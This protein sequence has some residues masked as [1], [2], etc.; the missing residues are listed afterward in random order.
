[1]PA[2]TRKPV[3]IPSWAGAVVLIPNGI[4]GFPPYFPKRQFTPRQFV[5]AARR[6]QLAR[7][8]GEWDVLFYAVED[9]KRAG[10]L[11]PYGNHYT[12]LRGRHGGRVKRLAQSS[13]MDEPPRRFTTG[14]NA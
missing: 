5:R 9:T 13:Y 6:L 4:D 11:H 12:T 10:E 1:M 14:R 8:R 7:G 2:T 3:A